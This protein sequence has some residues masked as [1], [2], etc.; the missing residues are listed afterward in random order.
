MLAIAVAVMFLDGIDFQSPVIV[1]LHF[2]AALFALR[3]FAVC[4]DKLFAFVS[5]FGAL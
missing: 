3:I 2:A 4:R 5:A 1:L